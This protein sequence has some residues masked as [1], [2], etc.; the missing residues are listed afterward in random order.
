MFLLHEW[1]ALCCH[2]VAMLSIMS[3]LPSYTHKKKIKKLR[4]LLPVVH[5]RSHTIW[6]CYRIDLV[7][8]ESKSMD[9]SEGGITTIEAIS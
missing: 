7:W 3:L 1:H 4:V 6:G 5:R 2:H 9:A 8:L